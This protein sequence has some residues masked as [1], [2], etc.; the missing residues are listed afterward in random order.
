LTGPGVGD[1]GVGEGRITRDRDMVWEGREVARGEVVPAL[2]DEGD[3]VIAKGFQVGGVVRGG[4][5]QKDGV[6][7]NGGLVG[8]GKGVFRGTRE[9]VGGKAGVKGSGS[10][11]RGGADMGR[12]GG[13]D[14]VV[15]DVG[16]EVRDVGGRREGFRREKDD[17]GLKEKHSWKVGL[18]GVGRGGRGSGGGGHGRNE[19]ERSKERGGR[20]EVGG[21]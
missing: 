15:D 8:T 11:G 20:G 9:E 2:T 17:F 7:G 13:I 5:S 18:L 19:E 1:G 16:G 3:D 4:S 14:D 21:K 6:T 12:D 10:R